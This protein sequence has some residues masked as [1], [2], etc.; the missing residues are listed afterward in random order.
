MRDLLDETSMPLNAFRQIRF[1]SQSPL[2][3]AMATR[4]KRKSAGQPMV[5]CDGS[6]S[7][8][9]LAVAEFLK[10]AEKQYRSGERELRTW[11]P[12]ALDDLQCDDRLELMAILLGHAFDTA[13]KPRA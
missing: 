10:T 8:G 13:K 2:G 9:V 5:R 7:C 1:R 11:L 4:A 6:L 12:T 3:I